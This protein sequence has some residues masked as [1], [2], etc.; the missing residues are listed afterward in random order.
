MLKSTLQFNT[1][2]FFYIKKRIKIDE[3][4]KQKTCLIMANH[5]IHLTNIVCIDLISVVH[6]R[7]LSFKNPIIKM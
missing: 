5:A 6:F 3:Q 2:G 4:S 7:N 1:R